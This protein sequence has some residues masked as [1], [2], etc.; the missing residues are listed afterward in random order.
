FLWKVTHNGL[1]VG[2]YWMKIHGYEE[3]AQCQRCGAVESVQHIL[4]ECL[5]TG[6]AM[7]WDL[8]CAV[9]AKKRA[10]WTDLS[11]VDVL[12]LGLK[13][14]KDDKGRLRQGATRLW[15]ILISEA[16]HLIWKLRCERVIGHADDENWEHHT[17]LVVFKLQYALNN[18]LALDVE[19]AK[20][21]YGNSA[22]TR[23][24]V[25]A[26][27]NGV[28]QDEAAFP[29]DWTKYTGFLVGRTPALR[30]DLEPD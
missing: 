7:I 10:Q 26:T 8:V 2:P 6:Q 13:E 5:A 24:L 11:L 4:F 28:L 12:A 15:R 25:H 14:W 29:D 20:K 17:T 19:S 30:V 23:D 21:K 3:R 22:L 9:W 18:R 1:K 16:V 27:W